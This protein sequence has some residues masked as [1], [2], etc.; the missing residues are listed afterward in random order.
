MELQ[1]PTTSIGIYANWSSDQWDFGTNRDYPAVKHNGA[2]VPGQRR[3]SIHADNR[4]APVIGEPVVAAL[5]VSGATSTVWQWQSSTSSGAWAN[6]AGANA[7]TYIPVAA[8]AGRHLRAKVT[9]TASGQSRT[10][11]T[12]NTAA[13]A[14][15]PGVAA[16]DPTSVIPAIPIIGEK[17]RFSR[18]AVGASGPG[19]W[20]WQRCD[21]AA[22]QTG[23]QFV[24]SS[25]P[26]NNAYTEYT[27][28]AGTD[29]DVGKY[30]Q[31]YVY[32]ADRGNNNA[33]TR[34]KTPIMGPVVAAAPT[35]TTSP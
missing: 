34:A 23:C 25:E 19:V 27:P 20:R 29:T 15:A 3:T 13:V 2:L 1:S 18:P 35:A 7:A 10:L 17:I 12:V 16:P 28:A 33:W 30:L 6:I 5:H 4:N 31:A 26:A 24:A 21:D 8:D 14:G 32:Y 22:M 11:T 9:F